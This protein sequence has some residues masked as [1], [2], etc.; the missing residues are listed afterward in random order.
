MDMALT[1]V[2]APQ[3]PQADAIFGSED[4]PIGTRAG[5]RYRHGTCRLFDKGSAVDIRR[6][7]FLHA[8]PRFGAQSLLQGYNEGGWNGPPGL[9]QPKQRENRT[10]RARQSILL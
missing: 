7:L 3:L 4:A 9:R 6:C 1:A 5:L 2:P 8:L 10:F